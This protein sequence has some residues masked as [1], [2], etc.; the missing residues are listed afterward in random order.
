MAG[1]AVLQS[2]PAG[3]TIFNFK[4]SSR[5]Q[6][7]EIKIALD[8]LEDAGSPMVEECTSFGRSCSQGLDDYLGWGYFLNYSLA[9]HQEHFGELCPG[10][11][12]FLKNR[13]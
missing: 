8:E 3:F 5:K 6:N 10:W 2:L 1:E 9:L 7:V 4:V 11:A 12:V 13:Q